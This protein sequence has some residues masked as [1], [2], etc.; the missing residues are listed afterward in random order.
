MNQQLLQQPNQ[1]RQQMNSNLQNAS[2]QD[3]ISWIHSF[4]GYGRR[5]NL[6]RLK[7]YLTHYGNPQDK[8]KAIHVVGTNGKG[9]TTTFLQSIFTE[10][11][12]RVGTFTSPYIIAFNER[13][14]IDGK[15]ISDHDLINLVQ[16]IQVDFPD[17]EIKFGRLTEFEVLC[18]LMF[19][20]FGKINKPDIVIIEAGI[21]GRY[22]STN[23]VS[24][25][26]LV[27]PSI[28]F[29]HED[30][31]GH[32]LIEIADHKVGA[33]KERVPFIFNCQDKIVIKHFKKTAERL[34]SPVYHLHENLEVFYNEDTFDVESDNF[35]FKEI[36]LKM[37]GQ[38]Q[39]DN[40][41][42]ALQT[43]SL[44]RNNFPKVT[45]N[46]LVQGL[47]KA[48]IPGRCEL[49]LPHVMLDGAHNEDSILKLK[50]L[51]KQNFNQKNIHILFSGLKR[52]PLDKMLNHLKDYDVTVTHFA[53]PDAMP[54]SD[55]PEPF[56]QVENWRQWVDSCNNEQDLYVVTGSFY[57]ISQ[58]RDYLMSSK[59]P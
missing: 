24:P 6:Q 29:D 37:I 27:C 21:G 17:L 14:A 25:L 19:L 51:L 1:Q 30:T 16:F 33:L 18:L 57:F 32:E 23:V 45:K 12:Y 9:S 3:T 28:S 42:L 36:R 8:L 52:K 15:P 39:M 59:N 58:V 38:H 47:L 53:F 26:A 20:Y 11:G 40:A 34:Q 10:S 46:S 50:D 41:S 4:K 48:S 22:D 43:A 31:L 5:P 54:L 35:S 7:S 44:L 56:S 13:I 55:Y 49:I 2:I